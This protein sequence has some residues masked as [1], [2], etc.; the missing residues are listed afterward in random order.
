MKW[1]LVFIVMPT[2]PFNHHSPAQKDQKNK[3]YPVVPLQHKLAGEHAERPADKRGESFN[4][5]KNQTCAKRFGKFGFVQR[6]A[7]SD[8]DG[9][10]VHGHT[11][12]EKDRSGEIHSCVQ[13]GNIHMTHHCPQ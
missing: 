3:G 9:K 8:G 12:S 5:A 7:F 10:S 4:R 13:T 1:C 6:G 11:K 2:K